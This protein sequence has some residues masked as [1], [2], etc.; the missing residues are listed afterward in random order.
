MRKFKFSNIDIDGLGNLF[1]YCIEYQLPDH[2]ITIISKPDWIKSEYVR[3]GL[4]FLRPDVK[5]NKQIKQYEVYCFWDNTWCKIN[6]YWD[7]NS[8]DAILIDLPKL[9]DSEWDNIEKALEY[10]N[11]YW[12]IQYKKYVTFRKCRNRCYE[13]KDLLPFYEKMM[14]ERLKGLVLPKRISTNHKSSN[15]YWKNL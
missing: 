2:E 9:K 11:D 14:G 6:Y 3:E 4:Y 5:D 8:I 7:R 10:V 13:T 12:K 1:T 15:F